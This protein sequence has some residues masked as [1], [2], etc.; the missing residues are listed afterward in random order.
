MPEFFPCLTPERARDKEALPDLNPL[1][2]TVSASRGSKT[3]FLASRVPG[4]MSTFYSRGRRGWWFS[5]LHGFAT[6]A[7]GGHVTVL[8]SK[9]K[10]KSA[11]DLLGDVLLPGEE[12][13]CCCC[14]PSLLLL[15]RMQ[16]WCQQVQPPSCHHETAEWGGGVKRMA[17]R[18][19]LPSWDHWLELAAAQQSGMFLHPRS[20]VPFPSHWWTTNKH[21]DANMEYSF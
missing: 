16:M 11:V 10:Q 5:H 8:A 6:G 12:A 20:A 15:F 3:P 4:A 1:P 18:M 7:E 2:C 14:F 17:E 21:M 13:R 9:S 19:A